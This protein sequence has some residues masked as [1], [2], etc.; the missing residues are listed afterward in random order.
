MYIVDLVHVLA[1]FIYII[2]KENYILNEKK[3]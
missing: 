2:I 1:C 3:F